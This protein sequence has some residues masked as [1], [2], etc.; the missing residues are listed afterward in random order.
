QVM[1]AVCTELAAVA[2]QARPLVVSIAAGITSAQLDRWLGGGL[3]VVRTMPN[4]PALLGAGVTGLYANP[5]VDAAGRARAEGLLAS[6][7][8]ASGVAW[9]TAGRPVPWALAGLMTWR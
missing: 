6:A 3:A 4:T 7:G 5:R 8:A 2:Q 1:R 9:R